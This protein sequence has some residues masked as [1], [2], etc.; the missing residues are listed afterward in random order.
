MV[1]ISPLPQDTVSRWG[2]VTDFAISQGKQVP[3]GGISA[4]SCFKTAVWPLTVPARK[5]E[6]AND[7]I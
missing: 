2:A 6:I 5:R 7:L 3:A 4:A 1:D